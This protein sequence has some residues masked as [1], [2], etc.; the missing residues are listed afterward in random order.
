MSRWEDDGMERYSP[1]VRKRRLG[2]GLR[3]LRNARGLT[4]EQVAKD[5]DQSVSQV[6]KIETA[7][8]NISKPA[9]LG[10]LGYY[11]ASK[12]EER[13]LLELHAN[14]RARGWFQE[15]GVQPGTYTD[16]ETEAVKI[17]S[18]EP[19]LVPGLLQ[20]EEYAEKVI[21][22]TRP[23]ISHAE[24]EKRAVV[25][26]QRAALLEEPEGPE[27]HYVVH[28]AALRTEVGGPGAM[29]NQLKRVLALC[30]KCR[31]LTVQILPF[32]HGAYAGMDG[33]FTILTFADLPPLA[34]V[35]HILNAS[36]HEKPGQINALTTTFGRLANQA[37]PMPE[38]LQVIR[39]L[40]KEWEE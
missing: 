20:T 23:E 19:L 37:L 9:L 21:G 10:L 16:F 5:L 8:R 38:S 11:K 33:A 39:K 28:E 35:E 18:F 30:D 26:A 15:Y 24:Q 4:A 1:T 40:A 3:A 34:D 32:S 29:R 22:E 13:E 7:E 36:W 27:I 14:S 17:Q 31:R 12:K 6:T 25:R 2:L